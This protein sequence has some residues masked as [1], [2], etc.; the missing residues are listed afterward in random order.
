MHI[1]VVSRLFNK[2]PGAWLGSLQRMERGSGVMRAVYAP[3]RN[4]IVQELKHPGSGAQLL[5]SKLGGP[6][7]SA[8]QLRI[9]DK[10]FDAF[11]T[12]LAKFRPEIR[13]VK[14]SYLSSAYRPGPVQ[15][16]GHRLEGRFHM[17]VETNDGKTKYVYVHASEWDESEVGSFLE[18]LAI[19]A[20]KRHNAPRRDVWFMDLARGQILRPQ[21]SHWKLQ[22]ELAKTISLLEMLQR[23][24]T[25]DH[26]AA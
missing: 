7:P 6:M 16:D 22:R 15:F 18:L 2:P 11:S 13:S 17:A 4:A 21:G 24:N 10:S 1:Y 20:A 19:I 9:R 23:V 5:H 14:E 3:L 25:L 8:S 26:E 12:F